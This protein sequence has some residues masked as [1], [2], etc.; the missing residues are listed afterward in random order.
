MLCVELGLKP[1]R[2]GSGSSF[3]NGQALP[4]PCLVYCRIFLPGPSVLILF[5]PPSTFHAMAS[6]L[7]FKAKQLTGQVSPYLKTSISS[8]LLANISSNFGP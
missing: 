1:R 8:L 3:I 2:S 6:Y 5:F 7:T 4:L